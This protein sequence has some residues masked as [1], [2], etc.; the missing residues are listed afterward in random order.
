MTRFCHNCGIKL[1][2]PYCAAC[3]QKAV[4]L[5]VTLHEFVHELTHETLHVDGRIFQSVRRLITSPGFLTRE[6]IQGHRARWISPIRL[7]LIFSVIFFTFSALAPFRVGMTQRGA[8]RDGWSFSIRNSPVVTG[9]DDENAEDEATKLGFE[10]L[11]ALQA[12]VN[13]ALI[14]WVPRVMFL[15]MPLF[16]WLVARSY[17][18]I[19]ANYLHHLIFAVHVHAAWF[20]VGTVAKLIELAFRPAGQVL[21]QLLPVFAVVYAVLAF[22]RVYGKVPHAFARIAFVIGVYFIVFVLAFTA[23]VIP[24]IFRQFL[25]KS[26]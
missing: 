13:S 2:G 26:T 7:Y 23:I 21:L 19:D 10:S 24:V 3:G 11:A 17:R 18:R 16:A 12:A 4:P 25:T 15:L 5:N 1:T 6:Y 14:A 9:S 22:R 20:A 8:S